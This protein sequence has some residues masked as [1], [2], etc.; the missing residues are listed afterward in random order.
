MLHSTMR[1]AIVTAADAKYFP[2]LGDLIAS[3]REHEPSR[4][5]ICVI[6]GGLT[7]AQRAQLRD[8]VAAVVDPGWDIPFVSEFPTWFKAMVARPFLP[9]HFPDYDVLLWS[10]WAHDWRASATP[11]SIAAE[12]THGD[13]GPG[14]VILL[15]DADHYAD[16]D[17]WRATC[18]RARS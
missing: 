3:I 13:V 15:H 10:R 16:P 14:D 11:E 12:A 9:K 8:Q 1:T 6:D 18:T 2:W 7:D 4:T 5:P 17:S